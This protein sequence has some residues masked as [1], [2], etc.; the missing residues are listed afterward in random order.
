MAGCLMRLVFFPKAVLSLI[1]LVSGALAAP[2]YAQ[3]YITAFADSQWKAQSGAF[4][5]SLIH[6]ITA[7]GSARLVRNA[8]SAEL[9]ELTARTQA[10]GDGA[11]RVEAVPP[12]WRSDANPGNLGQAQASGQ[13]LQVSGAQIAAIT[14]SLEQ[15]ANVIF[16]GSNLRVGLAARNFSTAFASY[17]TCVKN[18]IPYTFDQLSRTQLSYARETEALSPAAKAE[19]DKIVRYVKADQKVLGIIVDAHSDKQPKSEESDALSQLQAELVTSYLIDKG[20]AADRITTRWHGD[21][22]PIANN[23]NKVGQAKNRRV[24]VRLENAETRKEVE[25]KVA[26]IKEAEQKA[27]AEKAAK[28][29]MEKPAPGINAAE[30]ETLTEQQDLSTGKQPEIGL[31]R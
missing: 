14:A 8:G 5:C 21:K 13:L 22:F 17:R 3:T 6:D 9:L 1:V 29:A 24:T 26:A 2:V 20:V 15:G 7:F 27:A 16:S 30:L 11:V 18:L 19:L 12:M 28:E 23:Q 10:F 4:A 25:K 31:P